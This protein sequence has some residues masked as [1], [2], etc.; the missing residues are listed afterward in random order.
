M[1]KFSITS[2]VYNT[3]AYLREFFDSVLNQTFNDFE[4]IMVDDGSTDG[5]LEICREYADED[6]R[7]KV[8]TQKNQ[9]A[10]PARNK[11]IENSTGDYLLF[12]DSDDWVDERIL[13]T[14]DRALSEHDT[15]LLIYGAEEVIF[16]KDN[17][18]KDRIPV[19]PAKLDLKTERACRGE[20]CDLVF[21]SIINV[22]WNKVYKRNIVEEFGVRFA[23]TRRA[24]DAFFNMDYYRHITSL[25][26]I[27][28]ALYYY[29]G[30]NQQKVWKK[31]PKDL[32]KIDI[33][34]DAYMVDIFTEFGIYE[35]EQR[36]KIDALFY[37]SIFRTAG[38]CRNPL[39][40]MTQKEKVD[41]IR[42]ILSDEYNQ[43]RAKEA[44]ASDDKTKKIQQRI[45]EIDARGMLKDIFHE[46]RWNKLYGLYS[47]SL[48]R[49]IKGKSK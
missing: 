48:R 26:T 28:D 44:W 38:F 21:S 46:A 13:E 30:N 23:N 42:T 3:S 34:Y 18:E 27:Q 6:N 24:Q 11:G 17:Q 39:W 10:G 43:Q 16:S 47:N 36:K 1:P 29:R 25:Y 14:L 2:P 12:F 4:L 9:G 31:F 15:D 33:K 45:I 40:D 32:Y 8:L 7:I 5:S 49:I 19:T 41:Y 35:G 22:P 20:F 37:N